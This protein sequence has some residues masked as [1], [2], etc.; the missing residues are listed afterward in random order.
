MKAL[1]FDSFTKKI[2]IKTDL[3]KMYWAWC[4]TEGIT[5]WFLSKATYTSHNGKTKAPEDRISAG[6]DYT[7]EWHN[8][9]GQEKGKITQANGKDF[10]E[11]T[12]A[13]VCKVSVS[14]KKYGAYVL[15]TLKQYNIPTDDDSKLN[16]HYGCS[17]GWTFW[18]ANLKAYLEHG[19][20][21]N[22]TENDLRNEPLAGFEFVNM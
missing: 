12:F 4:T 18:L 8:W 21:L 6:D 10:I 2:Y 13:N 16:I 22:E 19:I 5:S 17:N 7:W 15:L 1:S 11:I 9:D 3:E 14:L 20:V